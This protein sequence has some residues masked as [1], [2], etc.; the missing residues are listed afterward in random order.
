MEEKGLRNR[1]EV[2]EAEETKGVSGRDEEVGGKE[3][4][5]GDEGRKE[6]EVEQKGRRRGCGWW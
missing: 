3:E 2:E 5:V 1:L 6:A 4:D